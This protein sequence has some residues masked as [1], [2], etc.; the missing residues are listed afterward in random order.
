VFGRAA[1]ERILR[2]ALLPALVA[3]APAWAGIQASPGSIVLDSPE[4]TEQLLVLAP[5]GPN[6][7]LDLTRTARYVSSNPAV[8]AVTPAGVVEPRGEGRAEIRIRHAKYVATVPVEVKGLKRPVPVSFEQEVIPILTKAG[9]NGGSC[10]GKA[11]GKNG[12]KLS[13]FGF[14]PEADHQQLV[15]HPPGRRV[16]PSQPGASLALR[17]AS[18]QIAH[19]GGKRLEERSPAYR[20]LYRWIAE[21]AR[22]DGSAAP[23]ARIEV[24][25]PRQTLSPEG[26]QQV[27]VIAVDAAG[28]RRCVTADAE[29]ESNAGTIAEVDRS[30]FVKATGV[31]GEAAI[32]ARYL[33]QI[34]VCRVT[35][36]QP[37]VTFT[38]PPEANFVDRLVWDRLQQL[39]IPPSG[40]ADDAAFLRRAYLDTIGTL[41]TAAEARAFLAECETE[42]RRD[43][44]TEGRRDG[45]TA[46]VGTNPRAPNAQRSTLNARQRLVDTL[47][48]RPEY[49]DYWAM[50]W[51][52]LLRV[53][54]EVV[55]HQATVAFTRWLRRQFV[56]NRPYDELAREILTAQGPLTA[57][58]PSAFYRVLE[59]PEEA[60]RSVSQLFLGTRI[61][62]AQCHHHPS[63]KWGQDDYFAFAGFF[64]GFG[65]KRL[66]GGAE[67]VI[68]KDGTDLK[69][70]RTGQVLPARALGAPPADFSA[71]ADR[72]AVLAE[73]MTAPENP[74]L[75]RVI[76]NRLWAHY[77]G[78]G[79]VEPIDDFRA[80]NPATNEPLLDALAKHL[81]EVKY[82][83]KA[84]TRTLLN[85]RVY[86]L[87]TETSPKNAHDAQNFSHAAFRPLPAEVLLDA[88]CQATGVPE[89]FTGW[90]EGYRAIQVWDNRIPSYFFR[91]FGRPVRASV[92]ECERSSEPSI[93]QALHLMNSPE[94]NEKI[95][96]RSGTARRL[97]ESELPPERIVEELF[98]GTLSR[99]PAERER[100]AMAAV[101]REAGSRRAGAEDVLWALLNSKEFVFNH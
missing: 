77:F 41:P 70:P 83:L 89:Q 13:V 95:R 85:S 9:C 12:F 71:V 101:F 19:A 38:R 10:H 8:A 33:G 62:C 44:G 55:G 49:A 32:L 56:E 72:R 16:N 40:P 84:F 68:A 28:R 20:R 15:F 57:E 59:K 75:A 36:P 45:E 86:A 7:S 58:G 81:R 42:R 27:R 91:V 96:A 48:D 1:I 66:P 21:G 30:G 98:L 90:P 50:K 53:D 6:R 3:A 92:C 63:E 24:F 99:F 80:T 51:A 93:A 61:E 43:R 2:L 94:I 34:A 74:Y 22:L 18:L 39:G 5:K 88:I 46:G 54:K 4:A 78:R 79:L 35:I 82:D 14:D 97:A 26:V 87:S 64:T 67:A 60:S 100:T 23:V 52:D 76:A 69:H 73:W 29:F 31:P 25:P 37:G 11:E 65:R 47:L 17:K